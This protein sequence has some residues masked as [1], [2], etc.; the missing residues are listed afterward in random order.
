MDESH[1]IIIATVAAVSLIILT[2]IAVILYS[3]KKNISC[4]D[5][6]SKTIKSVVLQKVVKIEME[7]KKLNMPAPPPSAYNDKSILE[8]MKK[9]NSQ[10]G[11]FYPKKVSVEELKKKLFA[12]S[13]VKN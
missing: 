8:D 4:V 10:T 7:T 6:E 1:I 13:A 2:V 12:N 11:A 3:K 9:R 5:E